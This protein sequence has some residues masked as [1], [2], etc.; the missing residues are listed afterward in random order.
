MLLRFHLY[1]PQHQNNLKKISVNTHWNSQNLKDEW[2]DERKNWFSDILI[3][4]KILWKNC[5]F[6]NLIYIKGFKWLKKSLII[7]EIQ[8][9]AS[10]CQFLNL[11]MIL[12]EG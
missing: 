5:Q 4:F 9:V 7:N 2:F 10:L 6:I 3:K 12:K 1:C 8:I 11:K